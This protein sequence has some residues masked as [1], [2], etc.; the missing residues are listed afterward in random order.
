[1]GLGDVKRQKWIRVNAYGEDG[2]VAGVQM[3]SVLVSIIEIFMDWK[4]Q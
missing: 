4:V 3:T 1:M 2:W